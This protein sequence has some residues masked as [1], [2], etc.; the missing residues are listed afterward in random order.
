MFPAGPSLYSRAEQ[1]IT[2]YFT[3]RSNTQSHTTAGCLQL[4]ANNHLITIITSVWPK[5][6]EKEQV[7]ANGQAKCYIFGKN[8]KKTGFV[9]CQH[10][11]IQY[12]TRFKSQI[13][14]CI[15]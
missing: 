10:T 5:I 1:Q 7:K 2:K 15:A 14:I 12:E 8:I 6:T 4:A 9:Q 3:I 11:S 13:S